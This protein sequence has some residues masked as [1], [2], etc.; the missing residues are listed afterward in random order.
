MKIENL[1]KDLDTEAMTEV[2]GGLALTGQVVPTNVQSNELLQ[3]FDIASHGPVSIANDADQSN[4]SN[5]DSIV[6]VGSVFLG[7]DFLRKAQ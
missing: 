4:Y 3:N 1:S 5:Q 7:S 6:P 2:K